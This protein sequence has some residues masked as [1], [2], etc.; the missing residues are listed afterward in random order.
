MGVQGRTSSRGLT[1]KTWGKGVGSRGQEVPV[2]SAG[3]GFG[4][5]PGARVALRRG[6]KG[7][8]DARLRR[9]GGRRWA[10]EWP[11]AVL[12]PPRPSPPPPP[13]V[14]GPALLR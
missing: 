5:G 13:P 6:V 10:R 7:F 12:R 4:K 14:S 2:G 1:P 3:V 9:A 8:L 11:D